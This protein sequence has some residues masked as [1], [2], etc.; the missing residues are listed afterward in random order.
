MLVL[1]MGLLSCNNRAEAGQTRGV[2]E[3]MKAFQ[4]VSVEIQINNK[5]TNA[6]T[7]EAALQE[8][9][10]KTGQVGNISLEQF[11]GDPV[12]ERYLV[13]VGKEVPASLLM[14]I[15]KVLR[16]EGASQ[17]SFRTDDTSAPNR[18]LIGKPG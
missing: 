14:R 12:G 18:I 8:E 6:A 10:S 3:D 13:V 9:F 17:A 11:D 16:L 2:S 5:L 15:K 1:G 4:A 7:L